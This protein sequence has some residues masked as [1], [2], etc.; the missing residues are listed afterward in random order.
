MYYVI[1]AYIRIIYTCLIY[2]FI[3]SVP[4]E[5]DPGTYCPCQ[6]VYYDQ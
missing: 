4:S 1:Y 2:T 3:L 5:T 6:L